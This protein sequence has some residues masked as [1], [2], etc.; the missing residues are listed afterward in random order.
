MKWRQAVAEVEDVAGRVLLRPKRDVAGRVL[1]RPK[2]DV[3]G[4]VAG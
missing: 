2:R 1:L 3:A 4:R